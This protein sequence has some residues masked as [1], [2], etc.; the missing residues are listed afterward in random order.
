[1]QPPEHRSTCFRVSLAL[2][3]CNGEPNQLVGDCKE[4]VIYEDNGCVYKVF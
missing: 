1:M 2:G 3:P 4:H